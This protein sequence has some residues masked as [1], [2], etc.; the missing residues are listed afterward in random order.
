ME[1]PLVNTGQVR[2]DG[3]EDPVTNSLQTKWK[4]LPFLDFKGEEGLSLETL[5]LEELNL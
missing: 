5:S 4:H 1:S 3:T 2:E